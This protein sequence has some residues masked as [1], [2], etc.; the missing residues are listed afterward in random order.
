MVELTAEY[1]GDTVYSIQASGTEGI[2]EYPEAG[3]VTV[4]WKS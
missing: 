2:H 1:I 3:N 4:T